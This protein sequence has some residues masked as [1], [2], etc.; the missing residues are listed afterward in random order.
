VKTISSTHLSGIYN[1]PNCDTHLFKMLGFYLNLIVITLVTADFYNS[2]YDDFDIQPLLE[3]DRIL[4][5]Y[6]KCFLD[7]GPC[8]PDAKDFK[9]R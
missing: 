2:K 1:H 3:N 6:T 8:T 5:G 7:E 9:S 4:M